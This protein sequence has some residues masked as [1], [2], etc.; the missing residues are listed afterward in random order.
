MTAAG[1]KALAKSIQD[2][3]ANPPVYTKVAHNGGR[4][5]HVVHVTFG[6]P[7]PVEKIGKDGQVESV[8]T[9]KRPKP[10]TLS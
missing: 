6:E 9:P 10:Y 5:A 7:K 4:Q 2:T 3:S 1:A 8:K